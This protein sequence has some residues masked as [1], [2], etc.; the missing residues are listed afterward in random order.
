MKLEDDLKELKRAIET[1]SQLKQVLNI[2]MTER[3]KDVVINRAFR[4]KYG[5]ELTD[6]SST[7][8]QLFYDIGKEDAIKELKDK[9]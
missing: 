5:L 6:L 4:N 7:I 2:E 8:I 3:C 1:Y 9:L